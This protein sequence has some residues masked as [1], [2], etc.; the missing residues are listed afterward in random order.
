ME[1]MYQGLPKANLDLSYIRFKSLIPTLDLTSSPGYPYMH[2]A[3]T[4]GQWL[5]VDELGNPDEFQLQFL[6]YETQKV[7][8]GEYDHYF[9]A[10]VKD[11]PHKI[12]KAEQNRWRL[13]FASSLPVQMAWKMFFQEQND[14]LNMQAGEI[15]SAHG[16]VFCYGG[17][18]RFKALCNSKGIKYS[19]DISSWDINAPGWVFEVVKALRE[20]D[21]RHKSIDWLYA[22]AFQNSKIITSTGHVYQQQFSGF[23]KSGLFVTISDNSLAMVALHILASLR[24]GQKIGHI[25]ATGDDVVQSHVSDRYLDELESLGVVVKEISSEL[26]FMGNDLTKEP[27]PMYFGK[28][29]VNFTMKPKYI[30]EVLDAY[31]RMYAYSK[32]QVVWRALADYFGITLRSQFYYKFWYGSPLAK[33]YD[34]ASL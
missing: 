28:H 12:A 4:I 10:F 21:I 6:W 23:M 16:W 22:D 25:Y 3:T 9:R 7:L 34:L 26:N 17:W 5:K 14:W 20:G 31:C 11:E 33:I 8:N 18:R 32:R 13:I 27:E 24:S 30:A 15:P 2:Q 29:I 1:Q 19:R